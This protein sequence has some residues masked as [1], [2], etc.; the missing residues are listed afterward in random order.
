MPGA[1]RKV[2]E[3]AV[4]ALKTSQKLDLSSLVKNQSIYSIDL[5]RLISSEDTAFSMSQLLVEM[6]NLLE[7]D[8]IVPIVSRIYPVHQIADALHYVSKGQHIGKVVISHSAD[9][10]D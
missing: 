3:I 9:T 2:L 4:H 1:F 7:S 5:R 6:K 10:N 8:Q